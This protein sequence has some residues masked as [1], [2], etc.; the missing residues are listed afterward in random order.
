MLTQPGGILRSP[1]QLVWTFLTLPILL[2]L[3]SHAAT[4]TPIDARYAAMWLDRTKGNFGATLNITFSGAYPTSPW[5]VRFR[6][7][8]AEAVLEEYWG[9]WRI[10]AGENSWYQL[11]PLNAGPPPD[12]SNRVYFSFN[13]RYNP[14]AQVPDPTSTLLLSDM[15]YLQPN[16]QMSNLTYNTEFG[17]AMIPANLRADPF[18]PFI[19]TS[20]PE[21]TYDPQPLPLTPHTEV[22]PVNVTTLPTTTDRSGNWTGLSVTASLIGAGLLLFLS[23][24][25]QRFLHR[26][27]YRKIYN[28][29][30]LQRTTSTKRRTCAETAEGMGVGAVGEVVSGGPRRRTM[31]IPGKQYRESI[32]AFQAANPSYAQRNAGTNDRSVSP[33][34]S[35]SSTV[36]SAPPPKSVAFNVPD[37]PVGPVDREQDAIEMDSVQFYGSYRDEADSSGKPLPHPMAAHHHGTST[38]DEDSEYDE[39]HHRNSLDTP[40]PPPSPP[41]SAS[42]NVANGNHPYAP[43]IP[44]PSDMSHYSHASNVSS[45]QRTPDFPMPPPQGSPPLP[46]PQAHH[47][48]RVS[49]ESVSNTARSSSYTE[50]QG[51]LPPSSSH[52]GSSSL[53]PSPPTR[54]RIVHQDYVDQPTTDI[55]RLTTIEPLDVHKQRD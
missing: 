44:D 13:G 19:R 48:T 34:S 30:E 39:A 5:A 51:L 26:R 42:P 55:S 23:T 21:S 15:Q 37:S 7:A 6:M 16:G 25:F 8:S 24:T 41:G 38:E 11:M 18:G 9:Q 36:P 47:R 12:P 22:R 52:S 32:A 14:S 2:P 4:N 54:G 46:P 53:A 1:L 31:L 50:P 43:Y 45:N 49:N 35:S 28:E 29:R 17:N 3:L 20:V 10:I 33:S 27:R 40:L